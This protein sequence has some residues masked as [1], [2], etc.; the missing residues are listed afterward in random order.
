[1]PTKQKKT[2]KK[3]TKLY[4]NNQNGQILAFRRDDTLALKN[5][6]H[7]ACFW[8]KKLSL[9]ITPNPGGQT[10]TIWIFWLCIVCE[11][12]TDLPSK[13][14]TQMSQEIFKLYWKNTLAKKSNTLA[15][16]LIHFWNFWC[17]MWLEILILNS[18]MKTE[19]KSAK[20]PSRYRE[21]HTNKHRH[22]G[23]QTDHQST[24]LYIKDTL[25]YHSILSWK[26]K[27][28]SIHK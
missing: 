28:K 12:H 7:C 4:E 25:Y 18:I 11:A 17:H 24:K 8:D 5:L 19:Q 10:S 3:L 22:T 6:W 21:K 26:L 23:G 14:R 2:Q 9:R 15:D 1:M 16:T 13:N 20:N 27:K